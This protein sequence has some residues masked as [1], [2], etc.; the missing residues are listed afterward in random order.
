MIEN[1]ID[2]IGE[3]VENHTEKD[4]NDGFVI[5]HFPSERISTTRVM[6]SYANVVPDSPSS[7]S[8]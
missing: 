5:Y 3:T 7:I 2:D 1:S 8:M 6:S 4:L